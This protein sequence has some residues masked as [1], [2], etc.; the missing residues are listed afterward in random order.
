MTRALRG[1]VAASLAGLM[2]ALPWALNA[3]SWTLGGIEVQVDTTVSAG[4]SFRMED[5][6]TTLI[7]IANG[8]GSRTVNEDDG[9]LRYDRGDVV[10]AVAKATQ[11]LEIRRGNYG[12]FSRY[13]YFYDFEA[14]NDR[15]LGPVANE[16]LGSDLQLLDLF[17]FG[18]LD[19]GPIP[20]NLR[21]GR[22]VINWG[23][24]TFIQNGVNVINAVDVSRL[25]TPGAE[26]R[27]ALTPVMAVRIAASLGDT[28]AA[29]AIWL[30]SFREIRIDPRRSFFS[31]NDFVSDDAVKAF[32]GAGRRFDDNQPPTVINPDAGTAGTAQ[33]WVDRAPNKDVEKD[34]EQYGLAL[35]YFAENLNYTEFG[36]YWLRYHSRL[37]LISGTKGTTSRYASADGT[38]MQGTGNYFVEYPEDIDVYG[39]SFN[40]SIPFGVAL[41][42]E[43]SYRPDLPVQLA[44]IELIQALLGL[45]NQAGISPAVPAGEVVQGFQRVKAHQVQ[46]TATKAFG[47]SFG[48]QQFVLLGEVGYNYLDLTDGILFNGPGIGI[49]SCLNPAPVQA[50]V[51]NGSCQSEGYADRSSWGYRAVT[52]LDY[53]NL[54]GPVGVSP[55][56]AFSHDVNGVGPNFNQQAK[57][58]SFGIGFNY[59]QRWQADIAYT[60]F[61]GGRVYAGTDPIP[62]GTIIPADP[63]AGRPN[64]T[65]I[66]GDASQSPD[67]A[68]SANVNKD[69]D[70]LAF[71]ISYAF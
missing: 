6:D 61:Y 40:T 45:P 49:S 25:R 59:L 8:G 27:E 3:K 31:T 7:G 64:P 10:G 47:P 35:R 56:L 67:F 69:R 9:N 12:L 20:L 29:E 44:A 13:S 55:R 42:G 66:P 23:E 54:L 58:L 11:D 17:V 48:A 2:L 32:T 33:V 43:Y 57:A 51:S 62:P 26:L 41:Q 19:L 30:P 71:N 39:L 53:E 22:Q 5:A 46:A 18:R 63:D 36:A 24:S 68:T 52:R 60:R 15:G 50:G 4:A 34:R 1:I 65:F 16:R 14:S 28:V 70:F 37:P 38:V 21:V